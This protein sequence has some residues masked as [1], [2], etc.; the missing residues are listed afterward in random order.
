MSLLV[1][2]YQLMIWMGNFGRLVLPGR[3]QNDA[4][5]P[6]TRPFRETHHGSLATRC[7]LRGP[8]GDPSR[9]AC[10]ALHPLE[11]WK[12]AAKPVSVLPP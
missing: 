7:T 12:T 4:I 6:H 8:S 3:S 1:T 11:S 2:R 9:V 10:N 5:D